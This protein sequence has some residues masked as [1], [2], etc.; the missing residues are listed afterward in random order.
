MS[1]YLHSTVKAKAPNSMN[2]YGMVLNDLDFQDLLDPLFKNVFQPLASLL[3]GNQGG[4]NLHHYYA[5]TGLFKLY[6][7]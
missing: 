1:N 3:F 4:D 2:K 6:E 7:W 5:F